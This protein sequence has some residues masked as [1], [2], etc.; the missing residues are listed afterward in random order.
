SPPR[1]VVCRGPEEL[2]VH[3]SALRARS[4]NAGSRKLP[5]QTQTGL[6]VPRFPDVDRTT[7]GPPYR[8]FVLRGE[9]QAHGNSKRSADFAVRSFKTTNFRYMDHNVNARDLGLW[10]PWPIK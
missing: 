3:D 8:N 1:R 6:A 7:T 4:N 9:P 2:R 10:Q 5:R